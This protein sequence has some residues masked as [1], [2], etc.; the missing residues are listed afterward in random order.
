MEAH[1][2]DA[3]GHDAV[4]TLEISRDEITCGSAHRYEPVEPVEVALEKRPSIVVTEVAARHRVKGAD[5]GAA[6]EAQHGYGQRR[7]ERLVVVDNVERRLL[8]QRPDA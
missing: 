6:M 7:H 4:V 2:V 5:V 3:V 1:A 8:E